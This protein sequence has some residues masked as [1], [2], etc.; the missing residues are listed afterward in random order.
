MVFEN[1]FIFLLFFIGSV[2]IPANTY[3]LNFVTGDVNKPS[4]S[5]VHQYT[6]PASPIGTIIVRNFT[7]TVS[8][9]FQGYLILFF[10]GID[11]AHT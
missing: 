9:T 8:S 6:I 11:G 1:V 10:W 5:I 3:R 4:G 2:V 7:F